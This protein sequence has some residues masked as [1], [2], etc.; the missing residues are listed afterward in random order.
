MTDR[1][2]HLTHIDHHRAWTVT[3]S[4][5]G[6]SALTLAGLYFTFGYARAPKE[7]VLPTTVE[8]ATITIGGHARSYIA[9]I[10]KDVPAN[11]PLLFMFHG[12]MEDAQGIRAASGYGFDRLAAEH[13]FIVIYPNGYKGNWHDCRTAATYPARTENIDDTGLIRALIARFHQRHG[14]DTGRVFA[15]GY[16]NGGQMIV[17]IAAEMSGEFAGVAAIAATQPTADNFACTGPGTPIPMLLIAGTRDPIVPYEGGVIS[18][19]GFQPRGSALSARDTARY[20]AQQ[21]GIT[22]APTEHALAGAT[23]RSTSV[24]Q[25]SYV[26]AGRPPVRL[27]T[28]VNGGHVVPGPNTMFPRLVGPIN[29]ALDA[30]AVIWQ[31]FADQPSMQP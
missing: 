30:P 10:P 22:A 20:F 24:T 15:A 29:R 31:F 8:H 28:V 12:S 21:N 9:V 27:Y 6:L 13:K 19:F 17:R 26:Q 7:P 5:V 1:F 25:T 3:G 4:V 2:P 11:A 18:L 23:A 14:I 16:S